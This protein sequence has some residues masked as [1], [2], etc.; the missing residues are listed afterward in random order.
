MIVKHYYTTYKLMHY[1]FSIPLIFPSS[2]APL[3][4]HPEPC[5][6]NEFYYILLFCWVFKKLFW[7]IS[8]FEVICNP[9]RS[10]K[11]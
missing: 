2:M 7:L 11:I 3:I 1:V 8:N 5:F 9:L 10:N 4:C 6:Q